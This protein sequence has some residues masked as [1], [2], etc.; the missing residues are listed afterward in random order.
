MIF[1]QLQQRIGEG[2]R[3]SIRNYTLKDT[4]QLRVF[5]THVYARKNLNLSKFFRCSDYLNKYELNFY[6]T[7]FYTFILFVV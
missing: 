5:H 3:K 7:K 6:K 4:L 1:S 2:N